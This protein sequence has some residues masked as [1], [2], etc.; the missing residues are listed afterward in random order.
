MNIESS[1]FELKKMTPTDLR[2][3]F[4]KDHQIQM[5]IIDQL[6]C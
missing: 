5:V 3:F 4:K 6:D 1:K 2:K